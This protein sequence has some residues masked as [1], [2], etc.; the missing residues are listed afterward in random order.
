MTNYHHKRSTEA[1]NK[2]V[3]LLEQ[4]A[5]GQEIDKVR[6]SNLFVILFWIFFFVV[7]LPPNDAYLIFTAA[8]L[9]IFNLSLEI[10]TFRDQAKP[11]L[12]KCIEW[13]KASLL[14]LMRLGLLR[15]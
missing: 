2:L 14:H 15:N 8:I 13:L 11:R 12:E 7:Q 4:F 3:D 5:I 1:A 6:G 9:H 10:K